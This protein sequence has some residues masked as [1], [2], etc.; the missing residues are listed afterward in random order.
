MISGISNSSYSVSSYYQTKNK[1]AELIS[2]LDQ[3]GDEALSQAEFEELSAKISEDTGITIDSEEAFAQADENEDG[4]VNQNELKNLMGPK[5]HMKQMKSGAVGREAQILAEFDEDEDEVLNETEFS[6]FAS[7]LSEKIGQDIDAEEL[8]AQMDS[9]EDGSVTE[10]E[11]KAFQQENRPPM[12]GGGP[13]PPQASMTEEAISSFDEDEDEALNESEFSNFA[14]DLSEKIGQDI[15]AEELF[16]QMDSDE[17]GSV[18]KAEM[19]D[20][21]QENR[22]PMMSQ[23]LEAYQ[24]SFNTE[25]SENLINMIG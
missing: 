3:D 10:A 12:M 21:H 1:E 2:N 14:S 16:A 17:D 4:V 23:K 6:N 8:F 5:E 20:F 9:D 24:P 25:D 13:K 15:N 19:E 7:D 18:T 11:M 22:P